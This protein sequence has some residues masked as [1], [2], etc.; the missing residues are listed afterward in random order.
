MFTF[1]EQLNDYIERIGCSAASLAARAGISAAAVSR[2]RSGA[3]VP[4]KSSSVP[5]QLAGA[6]AALGAE[7]GLTF[8]SEEI[9]SA[10]NE[11]LPERVEDSGKYPHLAQRFDLLVS[12][13]KINLNDLA[14]EL[15]FDAS[16]LS[17]I[18]TSKR[19]PADIS[20]FVKAV[21]RYTANR[22]H[23]ENDLAVLSIL[24]EC[25]K[26]SLSKNNCFEKLTEWFE[27]ECPASD[28]EI[29][30]FLEVLNSFR[31]DDYIRAVH[32]D[33]LKVP[34]SSVQLP[35]SRNYCGL[36]Q[37]KLGELEFFKASVLSKSTEP[38]FMCSDMPMEDMAADTDF[39]Q[40]WMYAIA[41]CLKKGLHLNIIHN[42]DRPFNEMLLGLE[43][44]IPIYMTG[45]I[46]PYH[47]KEHCCNVYHHLDYVSGA[48][49]LTGECIDGSHENGKYYLTTKKEELIYY[50]KKADDLL[51]KA[52]P[53]MDIYR[54][55]DAEKY[56]AFLS[57]CSKQEGNR[58]HML[59]SLPLATIT[60]EL[61]QRILIRS[62]VSAWA[63]DLILGHAEGQRKLAE[64]ILLHSTITDTVPELSLEE[65]ANNPMTLSLSDLF[66]ENTVYYTYEEYQEH[67]AQSRDFAK[68]HPSYTIRTAKD[69]A[70]RN[71]QIRTLE[72]TRVIISKN[73]AP[74]IHFVIKHP[75]MVDA[76]QHFTTPVFNA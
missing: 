54:N 37:M 63:R 51:S 74:A 11:T 33:T 21:C 34:T 9:L 31:L 20:G 8:T 6:L 36:E 32:F 24:L 72:D 14:K 22:Y 26:N 64:N 18:R 61:L 3:R 19:T 39:D 66:I 60:P 69:F 67:L 42:V 30:H 75:K 55:A 49:A 62:H 70:F 68:T 41:M 12:T 53:L 56:R 76:L 38:I 27:R 7:K 52:S 23:S 5:G 71:I 57:S 40:K 59:S 15:N 35:A 58:F 13:L 1:Q 48:A 4:E 44:W 2:Y 50:R 65:F 10:L 45:Q 73:Q 43:S 29:E 46:S 28:K 47:L 16:Y 17:R 25:N